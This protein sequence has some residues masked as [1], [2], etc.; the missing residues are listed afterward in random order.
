MRHEPTDL[1]RAVEPDRLDA[2]RHLADEETGAAHCEAGN[3][4]INSL[5]GQQLCF[6]FSGYTVLQ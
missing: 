4:F 2:D 5:H 6:T 1:G 3:P